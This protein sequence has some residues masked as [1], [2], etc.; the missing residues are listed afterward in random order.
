MTP[1]LHYVV[2]SA[3]LT[4]L[5]LFLGSFFRNRLWTWQ[6][7]KVGVGNRDNVPPPT[8]LSG[9]ADRA[10]MNTLENFAPFAALALAAHVAGADNAQ[11]DA[12]RADAQRWSGAHDCCRLRLAWNRACLRH[13]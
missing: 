11:R 5:A 9:R 12:D 8:P 3:A 2:Y 7:L 13:V 10:A 1:T 6:G 4:L